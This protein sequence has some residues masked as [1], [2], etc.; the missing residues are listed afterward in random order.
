MKT[1]EIMGRKFR[2]VDAVAGVLIDPVLPSGFDDTA[3]E[4]RGPEHLAFENLPFIRSTVSFEPEFLKAWPA[5]VR[6]DV[7][8][9]D[10]GAWDRSTVWGMFA[11]IPAA[12]ACAN[13]GP[14]WRSGKPREDAAAVT[15]AYLA[16]DVRDALISEG[17]VSY[18]TGSDDDARERV[19]Q[20]VDGVIEKTLGERL[21]AYAPLAADVIGK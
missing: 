10:G 17:L 1:F 5:G 8:C 16:A 21:R 11:T 13:A 18:V 19:R 3:N 2:A 6:F 14:A 15:L 7:R 20:A 4:E 9:L 12:L